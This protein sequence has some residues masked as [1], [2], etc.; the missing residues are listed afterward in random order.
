MSIQPE[1]LLVRLRSFAL[2][3][4]SPTVELG[5]LHRSLASERLSLAEIEAA[6]KELAV[7]GAVSLYAAN[8]RIVSV[9][10]ADLPLLALGE[11]YRRIALDPAHP[12]PGAGSLP[13]QIPE[14]E[15]ETVDAATGLA[16]LLQNAAAPAPVPAAR[17]PIS[18]AGPQAD[19]APFTAAASPVPPAAPGGAPPAR[20][21]PAVLQLTFP[22]N[23]P[24][25][26]VP[27]SLAGP[28]LI[29]AAVARIGAVLQDPR[30]TSLIDTRLRA[31]LRGSEAVVRQT[32]EDITARPRKA[33]AGVLAPTE[34]SVRFWSHLAKVVSAGIGTE[35]EAPD[36]ALLQSVHIA[37]MASAHLK[38]VAE[39]AREK[40][41]D[42]KGLETQVRKT[43]FVYTTEM[44]CGL[45]DEKG[46]L[47]TTKHGRDF[48]TSFVAEKT[49]PAEE[50]ILPFL[51][52][53]GEHLVQRDLVVPVFLN[54]LGEAADALRGA[55]VR[56]WVEQMR[57]DE[58]PPASRTDSAFARDVVRRVGEGFPVL[59]AVADGTVLSLAS[60]NPTLPDEWRAQL[61]RCFER[62]GT[63]RPVAA[64]LGLS[65]AGLLRDARSYL[66]FW[67]TAPIISG[68]VRFFRQ[69]FRRSSMP[70][71]P[72]PARAARPAPGAAPSETSVDEARAVA[73]RLAQ[74]RMRRAVQGLLSHYVPG[75]QTVEHA[76]EDLVERWNPLLEPG[77]KR[78]LVR[79]VTALAQDFIHPIRR[80]FLMRPPDLDRIT[81]LAEQLAASRSLAM[82]K[83]REPLLRYISIVMLRALLSP[84]G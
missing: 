3:S 48:I 60:R 18:P 10:F 15:I 80:T 20:R 54:K 35:R 39:R 66:P 46:T 50:G 43:P 52:R 77:P 49:A 33:S 69:L 70:V 23:V 24:A 51:V 2:R 5:A 45:K 58:I 78:D 16:V 53:F 55:Y 28:E 6:A 22:E 9:T 47:L 44:L 25:L 61:L 13:V 83:N 65:R 38:A 64:L 79:D 17:V 1:D 57:D 30:V 41:A 72:A 31:A 12:F 14:T 32:L 11:E 62:E 74:E 81:A 67:Q 42:R 19:D 76:L 73:D 34:L 71:S 7:R 59:A 68:I 26:L 40:A 8:N 82:I 29:E 84:K 27:R 21:P 36:A 75:E 63:L 4:K 56:E 37:A